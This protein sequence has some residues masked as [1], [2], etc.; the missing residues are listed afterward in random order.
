MFVNFNRAFHPTK[1][2]QIADL[3]HMIDV[4]NSL[5]GRCVTCVHHIPPAYDLPGFVDD[6][7]NCTCVNR[8]VFVNK[9]ILEKDIPCDQYEH[10]AHGLDVIQRKIYE[11]KGEK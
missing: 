1:E 9:A 4:H 11:L 5:I 2:Q 7:G 3:E 10:D 6:C 8:E